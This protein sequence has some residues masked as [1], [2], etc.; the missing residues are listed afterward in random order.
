MN[1]QSIIAELDAVIE[2]LQQAR[3][4]LGDYATPQKRGSG[5][6]R[7]NEIAMPTP[8]VSKRRK[9]SK[10]ARARIAAAQKARWAKTKKASKT[11]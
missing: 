9:L 10:Q 4:L 3:L 6:P 2:R 11:T 7:K 8:A 5:R 1:M